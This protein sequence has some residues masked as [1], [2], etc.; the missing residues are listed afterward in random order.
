MTRLLS[1]A[2]TNIFLRITKKR[3]DGFHEL[4]SV[5]Q[6]LSLGDTLKVSVLESGGKDV[7]RC[8]VD[9]VPLDESNLIVKA[10]NLFRRRT[11]QNKFFDCEIDKRTPLEGGMGGG[12]SNCA[13]ALWAANELC[14]SPASTN[15]LIEWGGELG[16]DV[17]FFLS[18]GT[19]YCT[20]RGEIVENVSPPLQTP[21]GAF[22]VVKPQEGCPT[23]LVYKTLGLK[24]GEALNGPDPVALRERLV[25]EGLSQ[26]VCVNDLEPPAQKVILPKLSQIKDALKKDGF[27][28]VLLSGSGATTYALHSVCSCC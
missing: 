25:R 13:T 6:A 20:G 19:A 2:K 18:E 14:G 21:Q 11:G 10:F 15:Q 27:H 9:S 16:S 7:L 3:D 22:W 4:A 17:G 24:P 23:P 26:E 28:T 8:N 1:P 12:S 5:F